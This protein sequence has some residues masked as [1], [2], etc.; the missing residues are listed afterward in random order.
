MW[1]RKTGEISAPRCV[2]PVD[3][4]REQCTQL[5]FDALYQQKPDNGIEPITSKGDF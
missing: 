5:D 3:R 2:D 1:T 4:I